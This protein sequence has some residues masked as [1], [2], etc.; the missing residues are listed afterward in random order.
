MPQTKTLGN[1][2]GQVFVEYILMLAMVVS[3]LVA[4]QSTFR[5]SIYTLWVGLGKEITAGCPQGCLPDPTIR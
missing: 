3:L 2:S 4:M 1:Q 5:S